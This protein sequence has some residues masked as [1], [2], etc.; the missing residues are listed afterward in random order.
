LRVPQATEAALATLNIADRQRVYAQTVTVDIWLRGR[1]CYVLAMQ[2]VASSGYVINLNGAFRTS[3]DLEAAAYDAANRLK[4]KHPAETVTIIKPDGTLVRMP[5]GCITDVVT[6]A[7]LAGHH[8]D[9]HHRKVFCPTPPAIS[10]TG[11]A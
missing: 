7:G 10:S 1:I 11:G 5:G 2:K 9:G 3:R 6:V 8:R 4:K